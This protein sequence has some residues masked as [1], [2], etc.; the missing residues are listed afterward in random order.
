MLQGEVLRFRERRPVSIFIHWWRIALAAFWHFNDDDGWAIA[1]HIALS[2]LMSLFPFFLVLT[3]VA[4]IFGSN[5]L[6]DEAAKLLLEAWP[7]EVAGPIALEIHSV[8][9][10]AQGQVLTIGVVL[11]L[12]FASSGIE[13]LRIGLNRAYGVVDP[14]PMWLLRVESIGYVLLSAVA[15]LALS[16]LV[17]FAPLLWKTAVKY[18]PALEPFGD[19][20]TLARFGIA[21]VLIF[22]PLIVVHLW[23]PAGRRRLRDIYPGILATL[24][25]WLVAGAL[26]GRYLADFAFTYSIYYAGLA[27]PM[28]ALVFLYLT[29]SIFIYGGELNAAIAKSRTKSDRTTA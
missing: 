1:S 7:K 19:I 9:T 21:T 8:L 22:V 15:L 27:S 28:I 4:G 26:F 29:A 23:L 6:A 18:V 11:A 16:F 13:S 12:Y 20:I 10:S 3:A 24:V 25:L 2:V 5:D 14:R 17:L